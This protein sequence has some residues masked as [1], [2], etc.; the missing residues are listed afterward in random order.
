M[1]FRWTIERPLSSFSSPSSSAEIFL[2]WDP[3]R[4]EPVV[5]KRVLP[6]ALTSE[7]VV[8]AFV[9]EGA[10]AMRLEH[11]N[12]VRTLASGVEGGVPYLVMEWLD[13]L[14]VRQL[15]KS[16]LRQRAQLHPAQAF[17]IGA[18]V[19]RALDHAHRMT[20]AA[21][22]PLGIVHRDVSPSNVF[23]T[24]TGVV[25][26]L[27]FGVAKTRA[28]ATRSGLVIGK[29]AYMAPEQ[30]EGLRVEARTDLFALGVVLWELLTGSRLWSFDTVE[31]TVR[32]VREA[33]VLPPSE[34]AAGISP[35]GDRLVLR[36]LAKYPTARPASARSALADLERLAE[37]HGSRDPTFELGHLVNRQAPA[38][39][40]PIT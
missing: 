4:R 8:Q 24:R 20:D 9:D 27:D 26:L 6:S 36:L 3:D 39:P 25:K 13:G 22:A 40:G 29:P 11:P 14:D 35:E 34:R 10:L 15:A 1:A 31:E 38:G 19:A 7:D 28:I 21:G 33:S 23:V 30:V 2:G 5:I 32:A 18:G 16:L 17:A 12:I 37:V